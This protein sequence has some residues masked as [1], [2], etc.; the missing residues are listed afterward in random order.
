MPALSIRN[1]N[2]TLQVREWQRD[3]H[4]RQL[5]HI[6]QLSTRLYDLVGQQAHAD[7][8]D[9]LP[10]DISYQDMLAVLQNAIADHASSLPETP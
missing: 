6:R 5:E 2:H 8:I 9:P 1:M 10:E 7:I 3:E 4:E